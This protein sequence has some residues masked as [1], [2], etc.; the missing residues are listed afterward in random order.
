LIPT[1]PPVSAQARSFRASPYLPVRDV[2]VVVDQGFC[3]GVGKD[4]RV[5]GTLHR[6]HGGPQAAV[7]TVHDHADPIHL[8]DYLAPEVGEAGVLVMA[9]GAGQI[10]AVIGKEHV[11]HAGLVIELH[12]I[13]PAIERGHA[14]DIE[15]DGDLA[16]RARQV[17]VANRRD[18]A[19]VG[20]LDRQAASK[21][22]NILHRLGPGLEIICNID[23]KIIDARFAPR[24]EKRIKWRI[25][26][27]FKPAVVVPDEA[28]SINRR[29]VHHSDPTPNI[30]LA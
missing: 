21:R 16:R 25:G 11:A 14:L 8:V 7:G 19:A 6:G 17:D 26:Q 20:R 1:T 5:G 13:G 27:Q 15:G 9:A 10:V 12:Q 3:V 30:G 24:R 28:L 23:G 4:H 2:P 18:D 22:G 29:C